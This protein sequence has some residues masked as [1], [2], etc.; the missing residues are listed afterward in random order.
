MCGQCEYISAQKDTLKKHIE[1]VHDGKRHYCNQ[2]EYSRKQKSVI[3][4]HI[5]SVH[6]GTWYHCDQCEYKAAYKSAVETHIES[7]HKKE[8]KKLNVR[9]LR[10]ETLTSGS[11]VS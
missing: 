7:V 5:E 3:K 8:L 9:N 2:C 11:S 1:T 6:N 10:H 4:T